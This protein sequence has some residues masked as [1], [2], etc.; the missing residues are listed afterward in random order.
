MFGSSDVEV[1][2][3]GTSSAGDE[4]EEEVQ[5]RSSKKSRRHTKP[6][7][8]SDEEEIQPRSQ[9]RRIARLAA[10][11]EEESEGEEQEGDEE[12]DELQEELA[13]LQSSPLQ[14]RG[15]LRSRQDKPK[16]ERE[17][18]L[19]ALK[20]R[21]AGTG[22]PSSSATPGRNRRVVVDSDPDSDLEIIDEEP[23]SDVEEEEEEEEEDEGGQETNALDMF[24]EDNEDADFIDDD[25]NAP[26]GAPADFAG[27]PLEFSSVSRKKPRELFKYA[28]EWMVQKKIN[29]AFS[30][31]DELYVL[32]FRK[33]DDEVTGLA[34]S[35][36][37]SSVWTADF[38]RAI[39]ARPDLTINELGGV[40]RLMSIVEP[41]CEACNR[42]HNATWELSLT[43]TPYHKE[44][45]EPLTEDSEDSSDPDSDSDSAL[46]STASDAALNGEKPTYNAQ[47]E[48]LPPESKIFTLGST[49]KANAQV[50]HT[51]YHW[52]Y[53][54]NSWVVDYLVRQGHCSPAKIVQR[55]KWSVKKREKYANKIV[56]EMERVGEIKKLYHLYK[57]QVDFAL[58]ARNDYK[59]GWGRSRG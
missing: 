49:C 42:K 18:A 16:S 10:T 26:I 4:S 38:T 21:R 14:D 55:D 17:K 41:R 43:G 53:H 52:R 33:L 37:H 8:D 44:T 29:P 40:S 56:D 15:R 19:E 24:Q 47:G 45:L 57:E 20:K 34:N 9:R 50:A 32:T 27:L 39:R 22:E 12:Q 7:E 58:E 36:F 13:F 30:S 28:V 5:P 46:S 11:P 6:V 1:I 48:R 54:L 2:S 23:D 59:R 3:S 35:K 31:N 25:A 51:L